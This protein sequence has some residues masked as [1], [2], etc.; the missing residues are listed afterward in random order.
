VTAANVHDSQ[1]LGDLLHGEETRV[2]GDSAYAGQSEVLAEQ[3]PLAHTDTHAKGCRNRPLTEEDKRKN[4][5]KSGV[6]AKVEHVFRILKCQFG[7]TKVRYRGVDK[8]ANHLFAAF[9]LVNIVMTK[10]RLLWLAQA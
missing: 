4:R 6:R 9:A 8:N 2:W 1:V 10:R 3:A 5:A 7:F